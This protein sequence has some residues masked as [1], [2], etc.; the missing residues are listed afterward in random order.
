MSSRQRLVL[1]VLLALGITSSLLGQPLP[2]DLALHIGELDN[3]LR[4]IVRQHD[5]PPGRAVIWLHIHS[6]SLNE[7]DAQRGLAHYLEHMAFNGSENFPPGSVVPFFQSLGMTFGRDQN[8]FTSFEQ[9]T[10]Q[11]SLPDAKPETL[12][13]GMSYF[14]D[15]LHRLSLPPAEIDDE[16]Q[17]IQEER[18][19]GL[20]GRQRTMFY[21]LERIAPG[22]IY[23]QRI[24]IGTEE[25]IN[26][27]QEPDFRDYYGHWYRA[28]NATLLVVADADPN[29]VTA[30][31][32]EQFGPAPKLPRPTPQDPRI[33]AYE[34]SFAIVASDPEIQ[35]EQIRVARIEPARPPTTTV[36]QYRED[37][38]ARLA[39]RAFNR[40]IDTKVAAGGTSY[41]DGRTSLSNEAGMLYSAELSG[42]AAPGKWR[43]AL[44][45]LVLELQRARAFGF[46]DY[47]IE[48]AR[49]QLL[50]G[51]ERAV[52]TEPTRP[53]AGLIRQMNAGVTAQE[54]ILSAQQELDLLRVQLPAI[55]AEEVSERFARE[56][57]PTAVSFIAVLP[58]S[59]DVP[60]EAELLE[61][62]TRAFGVKPT[63][64]A[65]TARPTELLAQLPTPG[66]VVETTAHAA[67]GVSSAW[68]SNNVR[69]HHRFMDTQKND[70]TIGISLLGGELLETADN[71]GVT[72]AAMVAWGRPATRHLSSSDIRDLMS[73]KKVS[74][75][76]GGGGGRGRRGGGGGGG[77][78]SISL[79]IS[80]SP[81][82]LEAGFQLAYL[83]LTEPKIESAAFEQ[84]MTRTRQMLA[85]AEK[86]PS[87]LGMRLASGAPYPV[88]VA[89]T[90]PV[91]VEQID[92]LTVD[93]AQAWLDRLIATSP[94]EVVVVGDLPREKALDLIS[95]YLGALPPRDRVNSGLFADLRRLERPPGPRS[96]TR[97][98]PTE[99]PQAFVLSAF[100]GA[101][102]SNV[103]DMR[104]LNVAARILSTRMVK[105]IREEAQLVYSISAAA[106]P[107]STYPGFGT[108]LAAS[109]TEPAKVPALLDKIA[110]M[111]ATLARDG[112]TA[113]ELDVARKQFA[114][115]LDEQ[116]R[117]PRFWLGQMTRLDF[118]SVNLDDIVNAPAD[119]Q[120]LTADQIR[121]TFAKYYSPERSFVVVATPEPAQNEAP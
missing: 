49:A 44:E 23:G 64:E 88:D 71:R 39:Q 67:S 94:I 46:T 43:A 2:N 121:E 26:S 87:R 115:T 34:Q 81:D 5:N 104:A 15:V 76:G 28:S 109:P 93:A 101:D 17:I 9:T 50:T 14:A 8:A 7:T 24:T 38:V 85:E 60:S 37:L 35:S 79:T 3:G 72:Q 114:N 113:E 52:E 31:I 20:S 66:K 4:Y 99:T 58:S 45:E 51:A 48:E 21:V 117:E 119:Y 27:V 118:R 97:S 33:T 75:R 120:A 55:T 68:L 116:M 36:P 90:Q 32:R 47:E 12:R 110:S 77:D 100:Y 53:A 30:A 89:R 41:L 73:D 70:V 102:E 42:Q 22:S 103:A 63:P 83:L 78:D 19:R 6:G 84:A 1:A 107:G 59:S 61:L 40:R 57:D 92:H 56:F 95:Q 91:T 11:L 74:V 106:R 98:V 80:G 62:G 29:E 96:L 65:E 86:N 13:K 25:T 111:Y 105:E 82:D 54:P 18:R 112:V 69:V 108:V 16:R 10:Y